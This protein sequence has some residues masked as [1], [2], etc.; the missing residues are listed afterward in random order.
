MDRLLV[1]A[2]VNAVERENVPPG[3]GHLDRLARLDEPNGKGLHS[4]HQLDRLGAIG[5]EVENLQEASVGELLLLEERHPEPFP[6]FRIGAEGT[7]EPAVAC[8]QRGLCR[9]NGGHLAGGEAEVFG[10][11]LLT[12]KKV[13]EIDCRE[14]PRRRADLDRGD[15]LPLSLW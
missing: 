9:L 12:T 6:V 3:V 2:L 5:R 10:A 11:F 1:G 4:L 15:L 13:C 8:T 7:R 14:L